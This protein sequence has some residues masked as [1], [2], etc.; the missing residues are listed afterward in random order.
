[1]SNIDEARIRSAN[2]VEQ[3]RNGNK[4]KQKFNL[5]VPG[6][7]RVDVNQPTEYYKDF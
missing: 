6:N 7:D 3:N 5:H 4:S 1:M 2:D